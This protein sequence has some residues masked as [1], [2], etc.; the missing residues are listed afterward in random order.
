MMILHS[1]RVAPT[2]SSLTGEI[3]IPGDKSISHR[4]IMLGSIAKGT[5]VINNFLNGEDCLHTI[6][7]FRNL[8]VDIQQDETEVTIY[9]SGIAAFKEPTV[10]LYFGNSGTTARLMLGILPALP[11]HT[12]IYGDPHLTI[13]PMD[14]VVQPLTLMG[15]NIDGRNNGN[16]LPIAI[17]GTKLNSIHYTLP[18][19]SAQVKSAVLLAGLFAKIGRAHV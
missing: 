19:K 14:R 5:S 4:S 11:F 10:P 16:Y 3:Q 18:V 9:S 17:R 12:V 8:G 7:M 1:I 2:K 6:D 13:R 15:A